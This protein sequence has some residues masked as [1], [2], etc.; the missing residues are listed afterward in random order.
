MDNVLLSVI[1]P[2]Y[3]I[4]KNLLMA[5]MNSLMSQ[6]EQAV[7][8]I[9]IDDGSPDECGEIID[10]Y[11]KQDSRFITIHTENLG[12]SNARNRGLDI[13]RGKYIVFV[14]GDDYIESDMC[15][16]IIRAIQEAGTDILFFMHRSS[17]TVKTD[18]FCDG[19]IEKLDSEMLNRLT[20]GV[21]SQENPLLGVWA[22][23][24]WGKVFKKSIIDKNNLRFVVGLKKSQD[25]V[26]VLD[27]LLKTK[28]AALFRYMGYHY[29]VNSNSVCQRYNEN[30][31]EILEM[32]G[33]EFVKRVE[34]IE[35]DKE[36]FLRAIDTMY[37]VFFCEYM[38]LNFFNSDN[39]DELLKKVKSMKKLLSEKKYRR[40]LR[41]GDISVISRKRR[42]F[43]LF[44]RYHMYFISGIIASV[45][46]K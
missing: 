20:I 12:V 3:K 22:G 11:E 28:T 31:V 21:I 42:I 41:Y 29:V 8:F 37:M 1:V 38:L 46:F 4:E 15:E 33:N 18:S 7:E 19:K 44:A 30:I 43:V 16:K 40:A 2:V 6:T 10:E 35:K 45:L 5:C 27:Y 32:A 9:V 34:R 14:D 36:M 25:R 24:P 17:S 39:K 23:P 13:A 26:F